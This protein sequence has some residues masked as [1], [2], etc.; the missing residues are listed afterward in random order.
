MKINPMKISISLLFSLI[1][2]AHLFGQA[3][4]KFSFQSVIRNSANQ[5]VS[6]QQIGIK[7][8]ILQGSFTGS[9]IY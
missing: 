6:N 2:I 5:L 9:I 3:P 1:T 7:I 4:E 8:S